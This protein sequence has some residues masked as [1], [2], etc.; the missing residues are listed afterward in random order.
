MNVYKD[1]LHVDHGDPQH[2]TVSVRQKENGLWEY[3]VDV[4]L[5]AIAAL[6]FTDRFYTEVPCHSEAE[7]VDSALNSLHEWYY[8]DFVPTREYG[9]SKT[10]KALVEA[11]LA[12][13]NK[14]EKHFDLCTQLVLGL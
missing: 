11:M 14:Q 2:I 9:V 13:W 4:A 8:E 3:A 7:A 12:Y 1:V 10:D 6:L 5:N